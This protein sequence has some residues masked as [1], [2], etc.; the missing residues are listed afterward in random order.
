M[1]SIMPTD[2]NQNMAVSLALAGLAFV[3]TIIIGRPIVTFL[4]VRGFAKEVRIEGPEHS[5][6][7]GTPTMVMQKVTTPSCPWR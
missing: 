7:R 3:V 2:P 5:R 4:R 1:D 6:K